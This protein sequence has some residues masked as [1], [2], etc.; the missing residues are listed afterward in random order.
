[1]EAQYFPRATTAPLT[2]PYY[3]GGAAVEEGTF[4]NKRTNYCKLEPGMVKA[5]VL[6]KRH[7]DDPSSRFLYSSARITKRRNAKMKNKIIYESVLFAP[8]QIQTE[9]RIIL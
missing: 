4:R 1:M 8:V 6:C 7:V 5:H 3:S 2:T 9:R